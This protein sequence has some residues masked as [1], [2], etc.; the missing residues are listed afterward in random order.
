MARTVIEIKDE[1]TQNFVD[2]TTIQSQ[3]GLTPGLSFNDQFSKVSFESIFFYIVAFSIWTLEKLF[4]EHK[5]WIENK[6]KEIKVANTDWYRNLAL[7]FQFGDTIVFEDG[8]WKYPVINEANKIVKLAS[9]T[10]EGN[11]VL[12]KVASLDSSGNIIPLNNFNPSALTSFN[13]YIKKM[14]V[15]GVKVLT[16]SRP[17]DELKIYMHIYVDP[18]VLD[19]TGKLLSDGT[20]N[21]IENTINSYIKNLPFNG[22]FSPTELVDYLQK[23]TGVINPIFDNAS[24]KFG[25]QPY[26]DIV[27]YY[28]P[29]AGYLSIDP[30]FP[31]STTITY[32]LG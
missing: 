30:S 15:A 24:A 4:D 17:A 31:L 11:F 18:L 10:D 23:T 28:N 22:K 19:A 1:L 32:I 9:V 27:D 12:I 14:K 20:T 21:P 7:S 5:V 29:N 13:T 26:S 16:V 8:I 3:Y 2:N 25:L 6:A